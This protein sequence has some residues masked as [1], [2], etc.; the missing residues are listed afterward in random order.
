MTNQ[1]NW[2]YWNPKG[3]VQHVLEVP[4]KMRYVRKSQ[5]GKIQGE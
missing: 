2:N 4:V 1:E 3:P 5:L